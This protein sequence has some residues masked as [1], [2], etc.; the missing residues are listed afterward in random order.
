MNSSQSP[1]YLFSILPIPFLFQ[2]CGQRINTLRLE[3]SNKTFLTNKD[4][5]TIATNCPLLDALEIVNLSMSEDPDIISA[6]AVPKPL[7][8]RF[9]T[10]LRLYQISVAPPSAQLRE[11]CLFML[12]GCPDLEVLHLEFPEK[13]WFF[14]DFLLDEILVVNPLQRLETFVIKNATITLISALRLLNQRPKLKK[15]GQILQWDVEISELD[16]FE[17]IIKRAKSL[18]LLYDVTFL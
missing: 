11:L 17:Q 3:C 4:L 14:S 12:A 9:L 6:S 5:T 1:I 2:L 10:Q 13:A 18:N 16:T 8:F 15:I 7:N